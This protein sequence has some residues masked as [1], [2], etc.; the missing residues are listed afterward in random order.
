MPFLPTLAQRRVITNIDT[1]EA[2][3]SIHDLGVPF[4]VLEDDNLHYSS[5]KIFFSR[6]SGSSVELC[7]SGKTSNAVVPTVS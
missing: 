4:C 7:N 5:S 1:E 3:V 2:D 6:V